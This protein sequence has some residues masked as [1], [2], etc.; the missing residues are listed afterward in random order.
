MRTALGLLLMAATL[1]AAPT[2]L[3]AQ[4][5][6]SWAQ[7]VDEDDIQAVGYVVRVGDED[8]ELRT[9]AD[10]VLV[11]PIPRDRDYSADLQVGNRIQVFYDE[12]LFDAGTPSVTYLE[13]YSGPI[14]G[15]EEAQSSTSSRD[16]DTELENEA[17]AALREAR[18]E[19]RQAVNE[20]EREVEEFGN[21]VEQ[22][23][24]ELGNEVEQAVDNVIDDE[25]EASTYQ[26]AT[27]DRDELPQ[28]A[29]NLPLVWVSGALLMLLGALALR[30]SR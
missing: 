21:E 9:H 6:E 12:E 15:T 1:V 13:V 3:G 27:Y 30:S 17:E 24:E 19:T 23:A 16:F 2:A 18:Q 22:E 4:Q 10:G 29:S 26:S 28:T 5:T 8:F 14:D 11:F 7:N 20:A 25:E